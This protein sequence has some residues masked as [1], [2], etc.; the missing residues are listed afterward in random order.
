[1]VKS[2]TGER[3]AETLLYVADFAIIAAG[4][5][6]LIPSLFEPGKASQTSLKIESTLP[7]IVSPIPQEGAGMFN[8]SMRGQW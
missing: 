3:C 8:R 4:T 5:Y 7:L 1:M 2:I 6:T